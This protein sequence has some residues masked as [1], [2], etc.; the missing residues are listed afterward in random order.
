[1]TDDPRFPWRGLKT[2]VVVV[3]SGV[4]GALVTLRAYHST[5]DRRFDTKESVG[6]MLKEFWATPPK[7]LS[8]CWDRAQEYPQLSGPENTTNR[9]AEYLH[10][11][12]R[13]GLVLWVS[14]TDNDGLPEA[15][16][17]WGDP[18]I[19]LWDG[20]TEDTTVNRH[21]T[22][23][24]RTVPPYYG[25]GFYINSSMLDTWRYGFQEAVNQMRELEMPANACREWEHA[26]GTGEPG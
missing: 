1:M 15:A 18:L 25:G 2:T 20:F 19:V 23:G 21:G 22:M 14:D 10:F 12:A 6:A 26:R 17:A 16:D 11:L 9:G 3:V 13:E 7:T 8:S 24:Q 4:V 5:W